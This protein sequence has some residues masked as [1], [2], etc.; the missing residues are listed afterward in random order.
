MYESLWGEEGPSLMTLTVT[1]HVNKSVELAHPL[2]CRY[3]PADRV[4]DV[5]L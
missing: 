1:V 4:V 5:Q 2:S 3:V